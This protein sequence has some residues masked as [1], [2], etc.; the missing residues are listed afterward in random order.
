M[1]FIVLAVILLIVIRE[2]FAAYDIQCRRKEYIQKY[3]LHIPTPAL[4]YRIIKRLGDVI[5]SLLICISILPVLYI[6]LGLIIK[7]TSKG[8]VIFKQKRYGLLG[9]EF[10]CYKS[11]SMYLDAGP[12]KVISKNDA[13]ITPIGKF[14]RKT[15]LDEFPQF[16][17]VF[18][19]DM[20]LVGPRPLRDVEMEKFRDVRGKYSR[21]LLRPGITGMTQVNSGRE[22]S[23]EEFLQY[24][25][26][27]V[28]NLSLITDI[29]LLLQTIKF[30]DIAY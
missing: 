5:I 14:I 18:M 26:M 2:L 17:N 29:V 4:G 27:Y 23:A 19:G 8:P 20:S 6:V 16:F 11:R 28:S 9:K 30:D 13:R 24:D 7:L 21:L 15:H 22:L 25:I 10:T 12:Q 3:H 1:K